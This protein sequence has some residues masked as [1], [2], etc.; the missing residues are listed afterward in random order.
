MEEEHSFTKT[1]ESCMQLCSN[2]FLW[3]VQAW[4]D[5]PVSVI[6]KAFIKAE[7]TAD[8]SYV[9]SSDLSK[10]LCRFLPASESDFQFQCFSSS[11]FF[12]F[13]CFV[14]DVYLLDGCALSAACTL[15]VIECSLFLK[16]GVCASST[17]APRRLKILVVTA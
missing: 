6:N 12:L 15:Y 14:G 9:N 2:F 5:V 11:A 13:Q 8:D 16:T 7:I 1:G 10:C 4:S 17:A 3:I